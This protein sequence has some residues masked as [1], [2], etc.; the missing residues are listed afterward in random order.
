VNRY[1]YI[2]DNY[3]D[4]QSIEVPIHWGVTWVNKGEVDHNVTGEW[5]APWTCNRGTRGR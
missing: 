3:F 5:G 2:Y 1:V 4:P